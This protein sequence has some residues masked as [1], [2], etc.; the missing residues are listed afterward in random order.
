STTVALPADTNT[1]PLGGDFSLDQQTVQASAGIVQ[2][3][4]YEVAVELGRGGMGVVYK[5]R[6]VGLNRW[7]ALKMVLTGAHADEAQLARFQTEAEAVA[8]L[9]HPNIVQIYEVGRYAGLPY[10]S[11]EFVSGGSLADK[12]HRQPQPPREAAH[13]VETLARAVGYAHKRGIVHRDLK[14]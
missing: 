5:A 11:L 2:V 4:G 8:E 1:P 6:Q 3:P 12:V 13:L 9:A 7:V 14:P 10:F